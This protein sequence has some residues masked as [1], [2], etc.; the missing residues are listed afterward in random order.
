LLIDEHRCVVAA[1][2]GEART[3]HVHCSRCFEEF[4]DY[5]LGA[6]ARHVQA[7]A[8]GAA[9]EGELLDLDGEEAIRLVTEEGDA[10]R[11]AGRMAVFSRREQ[12]IDST[13]LP[14]R[15]RAGEDWRLY[16]LHDEEHGRWL[17]YAAFRTYS[18]VGRVFQDLWV[19]PSR[20]GLGAADRLVR[21]ALAEEFL[22]NR[23]PVVNAPL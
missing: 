14:E 20:R 7:C 13:L 10:W 23:P 4:G 17:G 18:A 16:M 15:P 19:H 3:A 8:V 6:F 22:P 2:P 21:L 12:R 11:L 5:H 1:G 9:G